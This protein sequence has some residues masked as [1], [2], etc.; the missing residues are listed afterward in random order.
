VLGGWGCAYNS[1][2]FDMKEK[3][4]TATA[5][6][7]RGMNLFHQIPRFVLKRRDITKFWIIYFKKL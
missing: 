1:A 2:F 6:D 5:V 4:A 7:T 3:P